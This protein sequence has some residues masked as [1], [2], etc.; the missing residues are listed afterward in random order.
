MIES[1]DCY[2]FISQRFDGVRVATAPAWMRVRLALVG[3]RP[4]NNL[5]DVS[6]YVMLETGPAAA[7]LR[8]RTRPGG[9]LIVRRR[10]RGEKLVTLDGVDRTLSPQALVIADDERRSGSPDSWAARK[11]SGR[12]HYDD[13]L[14]SANFNGARIR[15]MS[16]A[17]G[18]R[19]E[20]SSR[21][22]KSLALA[23]TEIG[24][25]RAAQLL[26]DLGALPQGHRMHSV[27][28]PL[29]PLRSNFAPLPTSTPAG[30]PPFG[31]PHCRALAGAGMR[32]RTRDG[33]T[34]MVTPPPWRRDLTIANDLIEEVARIEGYER[35]EASVPSVPAHAISSAAFERQN[36]IATHSP[37]WLSRDRHAFAASRAGDRAVAVRNPLSEDQRLLRDSLVPGNAGYLATAPTGARVFEIGEIFHRDRE[38]IVEQTALAFGFCAQRAGE[39]AWRDT[40]FLRLKGDCEALLRG[41]AGTKPTMSPGTYPGF[42]P[43]KTGRVCIGDVDAGVLG[44]I[45]PRLASASDIDGNAYICLLDV[46]VLPRYATP[47][48]RPPSRFPSTY[49]DLALVVE[50]DVSARA[51]EESIAGAVGPL[52][53]GVTVFDEY[54]G[55]QVGDGP[56]AWPCALRS[57]RFDATITDEEADEAVA[58]VLDAVRERFGATMRT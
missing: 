32:R 22:E 34:A 16:N 40:Q 5:V 20:A 50:V 3:Q 9:R 44:C 27:T 52:C 47:R 10:A 35:I 33:E 24:A 1:S 13:A 48:Y 56:R 7:F 41:I 31:G 2:R 17:L 25:A 49:R 45:D 38:R 42:H 58:R 12:R 11:R 26:C 6:N 37:A 54:R 18:L 30:I 14:E 23:L 36:A 53:T 55:Q 15:R 57:Q 19:T 39:P 43:G 8:C 51:L 21:H 4:I 29:P 28:P 46:G